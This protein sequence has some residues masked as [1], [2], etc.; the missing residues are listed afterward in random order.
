MI[1]V[2]V[3]D[4]LV[5]IMAEEYRAG[6]KATSAAMTAAAEGV[7]VEWRGQFTAAGLGNLSRSVKARGFPRQ[8]SMNAAALAYV[9]PRAAARAALA[10]DQGAVIRAQRGRF[11]AIPTEAAGFRRGRGRDGQFSGLTPGEWERRTGQRLRLISR[12]GRPSLLVAEGRLGKA[13][14]YAVSRS[15]TGRGLTTVVIFVLVPQ[16]TLR[17]RL[18]LVSAADRW[19]SALPGMIVRAWA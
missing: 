19:A 18:D 12:R 17:R 9:E 6:Q 14:R 13:G 3:L 1:R 7:K 15:K 4:D 10:F 16:V 8:P 11:L 5:A 2:D